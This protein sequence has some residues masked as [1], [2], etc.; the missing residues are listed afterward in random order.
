MYLI[1]KLLSPAHF[2][3]EETRIKNVETF[4]RSHSFL[5]VDQR[6]A[7]ANPQRKLRSI[8]KFRRSDL[9]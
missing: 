7:G 9:L 2:R 5:V 4:S 6:T 8:S 1:L 3:D